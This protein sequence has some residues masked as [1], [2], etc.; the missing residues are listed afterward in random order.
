ME[1]KEHESKLAVPP[2]LL[3]N[4]PARHCK[5][6]RLDLCHYVGNFNQLE[7][8]Y[9]HWRG[10]NLKGEHVSVRLGYSLS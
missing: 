4:K 9:C 2:E 5:L 3:E 10:G 8:S 6:N 7:I 1:I